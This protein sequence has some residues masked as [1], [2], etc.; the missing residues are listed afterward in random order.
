MNAIATE[1]DQPVLA[2]PFGGG[3]FV[4]RMRVDGE[5]YGL[6]VAPRAEGETE[7]AWND[8]YKTVSGALSW[9]DGLANTQAMA[10]AGSNLAKWALGLDIA[11]YTD[12]YI[13]AQDELEVMYRALKPT[14]RENYQYARSGINLS[15]FEPTYPYTANR[16]SQTLSGDFKEGGA[17]AFE[18]E[19]YWSSTQHS[20]YS[21][22]AWG[23]SFSDGNQDNSLKVDCFRARAVR[24][25]KL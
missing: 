18:D 9:H 19:W 10:E 7:M 12:W 21:Y 23:Q 6:I 16:P 17:E 20:D 14:T 4:G 5:V 8:N 3:F 15:A 13:P 11:G 2:V 25:F 24:R 1:T 22:C